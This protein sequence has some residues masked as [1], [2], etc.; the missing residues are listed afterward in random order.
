MR[1]VVACR[2]RLRCV[3]V[4]GDLGLA[5]WGFPPTTIQLLAHS[6]SPAFAPQALGGFRDRGFHDQN[7]AYY[8][9]DRAGRS[10]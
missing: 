10:L 7:R 1:E 2:T 3:R 8:R 4:G 6:L 5:V 9:S